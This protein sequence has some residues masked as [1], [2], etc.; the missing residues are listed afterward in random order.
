M[1]ADEVHWSHGDKA[2]SEELHMAIG[3]DTRL[4]LF[5][6]TARDWVFTTG[7]DMD[8][9]K[10]YTSKVV[11]MDDGHNLTLDGYDESLS[12]LQILETVWFLRTLWPMCM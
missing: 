12:C 4:M 10:P 8:T 5:T 9:E 6:G 2:P 7:F 11:M 3:A 1:L